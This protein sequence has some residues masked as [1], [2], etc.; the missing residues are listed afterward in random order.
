MSFTSFGSASRDQFEPQL[1]SLFEE[2]QSKFGEV[3]FKSVDAKKKCVRVQARI[4]HLDTPLAA[5]GA[6]YQEA[7][8]RLL[9][10]TKEI[11]RQEKK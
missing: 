6:T 1:V 2:L 4:G 5:L 10:M 8:E 11:E 9:V 3:E 7:A